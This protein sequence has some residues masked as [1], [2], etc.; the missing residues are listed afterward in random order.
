MIKKIA[1]FLC[2][3]LGVNSNSQNFNNLELLLLAS[4]DD[5]SLL[6]KE[7]L[8]PLVT[9]INF[10]MASGWAHT[11]KTHKKF[12]FDITVSANAFIIPSEE[13]NFA[14]SEFNNLT[15]SSEYLPTVLGGSSD[16][17]IYVSII[18]NSDIMPNNLNTVFSAPSGIK[19]NLPLD[20]LITPNIQLGLGL[21][22]KTDLIIRYIPRRSNKNTNLELK[23]IGLKHDLLQH[24]GPADNAPLLNLSLLATYS[25]YNIN[26]NIQKNSNLSGF[27]QA[28]NINMENYLIQLLSSIDI[29]LIT[30]YAGVGVSKGLST[31]NL[32]GTYN[33]NYSIDD[34]AQVYTVSVSDPL[35]VKWRRES[36][37][38][39]AGISFNFPGIKVFTDYSYQE[40][41]SITF[42]FSFGIR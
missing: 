27:G 32:L 13:E 34:T 6:F 19:E 38:A 3:S 24:F 26:Y 4:E 18:N 5:R 33:L 39:K 23:G 7:Y 14:T 12:G 30:L 15:S 10:G 40:F 25:N 31:L 42:G 11:A 17:T 20:M 2:I 29:K 22:F 36:M 37:S 41:N 21:P 8:N 28:A 1:L 9:S 16:E 35:M